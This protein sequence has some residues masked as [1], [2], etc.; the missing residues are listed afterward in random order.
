PDLARRDRLGVHGGG[1]ATVPRGGVS[2]VLRETR[3]KTVPGA[4]RRTSLC[5]DGLAEDVRRSAATTGNARDRC[6][7]LDPFD[8]ELRVVGRAEAEVPVV[9]GG[10]RGAQVRDRRFARESNRQ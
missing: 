9:R 6:F 2:N 3:R 4:R 1:A 7:E 5:A 8:D 10:E